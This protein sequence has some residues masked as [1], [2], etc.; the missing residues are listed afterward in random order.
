[1]IENEI[2]KL[3]PDP[4]LKYKLDDYKNFNKDLEKY[5]YN[6]Y[7]KDKKGLERSNR[8]GW[9]SENFNLLEQDSIQ[10]K[11]AIK[12]QEYVLNCFQNM[13]WKIKDK[14]IRIKEMWAI[15]N[16][17]ENFNVIHIHPNCY[18]SSAYYVKASKDCG[19]F[20]AENPNLA[21]RYV[22]PEIVNKNELNVETARINIEEGD[23]LLFPS[24]LPH[25]VGKNESSDD[26]I[27]I[28]FNVD[29]K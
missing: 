20:I 15:I 21:K 10:K 23:L 27:V 22:Y 12:V 6:L 18:L 1:M 5:I 11:F 16:K 3:F 2:L 25:R 7:E 19:E 28:S 17:K 9:H 14:N 26:R 13:G 4:V 29:I 24:Y 8:G